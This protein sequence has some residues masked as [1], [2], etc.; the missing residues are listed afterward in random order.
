MEDIDVDETMSGID[1]DVH[2]LIINCK[3]YPGNKKASVEKITDLFGVDIF[4]IKVKSIPENNKANIEA[5][6]LLSDYFNVRKKDVSILK[7]H[8]SSSKVVQICLQK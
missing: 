5:I 1:I 4:K 2:K 8:T 6:N 3:I 7:G